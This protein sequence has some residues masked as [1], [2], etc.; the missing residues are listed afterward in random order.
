MIPNILT[1]GIYFVISIISLFTLFASND[2]F[3]FKVKYSFWLTVFLVSI[4]ATLVYQQSTGESYS[5]LRYAEIFLFFSYVNFTG[6]CGIENFANKL[7]KVKEGK[8]TTDASTIDAHMRGYD[9]YEQQT[10][11][12]NW[13]DKLSFIVRNWQ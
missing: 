8:K 13:R 12:M 3:G 9:A 11:K 1:T 2:L 10:E 7:S 6:I 5:F 4:G